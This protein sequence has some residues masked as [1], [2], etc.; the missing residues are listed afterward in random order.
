MRKVG[1]PS[2]R[3]VED[4]AQFPHLALFV[5]DAER[6]LLVGMVI[7]VIYHIVIGFLLIWNRPKDAPNILL[8]IAGVLISVLLGALGGLIPFAVM[9]TRPSLPQ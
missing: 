7:G 3:F 6:G 2:W 1:S 8:Y 4:E 9:T 5:R